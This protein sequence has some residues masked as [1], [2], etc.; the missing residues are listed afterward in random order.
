MIDDR[1]W[2]GQELGDSFTTENTEINSGYEPCEELCDLSGQVFSP[3]R[4]L[5]LDSRFRGNDWV[6]AALAVVGD[7]SVDMGPT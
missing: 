3:Q 6:G 7:P 4:T 2:V 5:I 1:S